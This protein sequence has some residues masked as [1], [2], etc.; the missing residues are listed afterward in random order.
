[1]RLPHVVRSISKTENWSRVWDQA[2]HSATHLRNV[3]LSISETDKWSSNQVALVCVFIIW[4]LVAVIQV[5]VGP[6]V[7]TSASASTKSPGEDLS[8][9]RARFHLMT[10]L[11]FINILK[12]CHLLE[13]LEKLWVL[14][15]G[16]VLHFV[17]PIC[18]SAYA[19]IDGAAS[20]SGAHG[21]RNIVDQCVAPF[22]LAS[23]AARLGHLALNAAL[24]G[25]WDGSELILTPLQQLWSCVD[26]GP[27]WYLL[28]LAW[29]QLAVPALKA[30][31]L[32]I[33]VAILVA[34]SGPRGTAAQEM[35]AARE[36]F[37]FLPCFTLGLCWPQTWRM[38]GLLRLVALVWYSVCL[39]LLFLTHEYVAKSEKQEQLMNW[40]S[41]NIA[42]PI[43]DG[44]MAPDAARYAFYGVT[45]I[46][47]LASLGSVPAPGAGASKRT[48]Y[49]LVMH[50]PLARAAMQML[51]PV[52][53]DTLP[54]LEAS[55][56]L[57]VLAFLMNVVLTS[58]V[59]SFFFSWILEPKSWLNIMLWGSGASKEDAGGLW[60]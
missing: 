32:P 45:A 21:P 40:W 4:L 20:R 33:L 52:A 19:F 57:F 55:L 7:G 60:L 42:L 43:A 51:D 13:R 11:V 16:F 8:W 27:T 37:F 18:I 10:F 23:V 41:S 22:L 1:M 47:L 5:S 56:V 48:T 46:A 29:W 44:G 39:A 2:S 6:L 12:L 31:R 17:E 15:P 50:V 38:D 24:Q 25:S 3:A 28:A 53:A 36:A 30:M 9:S 35:Y 58:P 49:A 14:V 54:P 34:L 59:T 26:V